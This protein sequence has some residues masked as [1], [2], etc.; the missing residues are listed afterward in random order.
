MKKGNF[1]DEELQCSKDSAIASLR[2]VRESK[3]LS[4]MFKY[5]NKIA[6]K[7]D[8]SFEEIEE[9]YKKI[10]REDIIRV[11]N[12]IEFTNEFIIGGVQNA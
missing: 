1:T 8:M 5:S 11:A 3:Y 2:D 7:K 6:Y 4:C 9:A 12:K 10:T